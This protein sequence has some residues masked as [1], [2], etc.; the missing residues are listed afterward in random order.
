MDVIEEISPNDKMYVSS[1]P[2]RY[3]ELGESA[4][5][6]IRLSL[7]AAEQPDPQNILD[8]P[9]GHGRVLRTLKAAFPQARLT[10]CD[11]DTDAIEFCSRVL[12]ATPVQGREDPSEVDLNDTF[13][14]IWVGSLLTH[15]DAPRW[16]EFF[17]FFWSVLKPDGL[18]VF[19][20]HGHKVL[21][22]MRDGVAYLPEELQAGVIADYEATGFGYRNYVGQAA[23]GISLSASWWVFPRL[24]GRVHLFSEA[25]WG[26]HDV[27]AVSPY[28]TV[29]A[30][31][32]AW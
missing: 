29:P 10:A 13:D 26:S 19:T 6:A 7:Q 14:L 12:G 3:W 27:F 9:S 17:E 32:T 4:V 18:L 31:G 15:I 23:Y 1:P 5:Q 21:K 2:E 20:V 16:L 28:R 22:N 30:H 25:L 11:T 24:E 8:L